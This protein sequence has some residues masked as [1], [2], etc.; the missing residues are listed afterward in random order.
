MPRPPRFV[1]PGIPHHV[2][3]RGNY[4]QTT[5]FEDRDY[6]FYLRLLRKYAQRFDVAVQAYCLMPNH[7][8]LIVTPSREDSLPALLQRLHSDYARSVHVHRERVGHLWQSR[9][10]STPLDEAHFWHAMTYVE[11]NPERAGLV[12]KCWHW[13]WSSAASRLRG[14]DEGFL[15]LTEW[16][17]RHSPSSWI[18]CLQLGVRDAELL[19]R[20]RENT[21]TGWPLGSDRFL[22]GI[23]DRL[24]RP[25]RPGPPGRKANAAPGIGI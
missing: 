12:E 17:R 3:Q 4:R 20:I 21:N 14:S 1:I 11:Q 9:Y 24:G 7:V 10:Y 25:A 15:D 13:C 8:H 2:T 18:E 19:Q 6:L 23:A 16:K 22:D 5:F